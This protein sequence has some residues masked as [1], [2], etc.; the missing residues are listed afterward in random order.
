CNH[1]GHDQ[2]EVRVTATIA[3]RI[4]ENERAGGDVVLT[5]GLTPVR[6]FPGGRDVVRAYR[7]LIERGEPG[8]S[9]NVC[10]GRGIS[11]QELADRL[12]G[13]ATRPMRLEVD[14]ERLRPV[15]VPVHWGDNTRLR[16]ATGWQPS[17]GLEQSLAEILEWWREKA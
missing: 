14:R 6:D 11:M 12:L 9:Y 16:S 2:S 1:I 7:L 8:E 10:S 3:K 13:M 4:A 15:E 17:I 5:G